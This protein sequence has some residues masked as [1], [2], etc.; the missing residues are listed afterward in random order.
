MTKEDLD[1]L[2]HSGLGG[3][4]R[5]LRGSMVCLHSPEEKN[6]YDNIINKN[7]YI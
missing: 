3:V 4:P 5:G 6:Y 2:D 1:G 7:Y